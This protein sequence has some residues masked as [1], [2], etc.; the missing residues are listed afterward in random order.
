MKS[1]DL[2]L[3]KDKI[4]I[5]KMLKVIINRIVRK[6]GGAGMNLSLVKLYGL[7]VCCKHS[8]FGNC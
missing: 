3:F 4:K 6:Y 7:Q 1:V 5:A 8:N 2:H